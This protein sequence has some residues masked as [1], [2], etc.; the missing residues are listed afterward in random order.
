MD[1][2]GVGRELILLYKFGP[3]GG[4]PVLSRPLGRL[5]AAAAAASG[6]HRGIQVVTAVPSHRARIRERGFDAARLLA[7]RLCRNLDLPAPRRLLH[8]QTAQPPR[9]RR[10]AWEGPGP[11]RLRPGVAPWLAGRSVLLVD[12]VLTT[13]A[14]VRSCCRL[15]SA[16][17]AS[18]V[19]VLALAWTP[20]PGRHPLDRRQAIV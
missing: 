13:G 6:I 3:G 12:D 8:R 16:A 2:R 9:W 14:T 4:R 20:P 19:R 18:Q 7:R 11:F 15:L 17:G 5:L 1:Y 10:R